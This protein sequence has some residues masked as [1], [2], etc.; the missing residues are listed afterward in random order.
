MGIPAL[1]RAPAL[2]LDPPGTA[3]RDR[4]RGM[5][6]RFLTVSWPA[7]RVVVVVTTTNFDLPQP[8]RVTAKLLMAR[9]LPALWRRAAPPAPRRAGGS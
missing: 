6:G 7:Q 9:I 2:V 5:G 3:H 4:V 8:H 1:C